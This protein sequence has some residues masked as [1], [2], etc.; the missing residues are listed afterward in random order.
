MIQIEL[1]ETTKSLDDG[2]KVKDQFSEFIHPVYRHS[3]ILEG[4]W[5]QL[6]CVTTTTTLWTGK[7]L[8]KAG[9]RL[10]LAVD[11]LDLHLEETG[12][13]LKDFSRA[14]E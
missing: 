6:V 12:I 5:F 1:I 4:K 14:L 9:R 10:V 11:Q 7:M 2:S 3:Y 13:D 8:C